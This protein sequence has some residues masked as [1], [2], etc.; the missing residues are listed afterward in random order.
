M[1]VAAPAPRERP[2]WKWVGAT[3]LLLSMQTVYGWLPPSIL[4]HMAA[5]LGVGVRAVQDHFRDA[6]RGI[7]QSRPAWLLPMHLVAVQEC[8]DFL[9]AWRVLLALDV[10]APYASVERALWEAPE[11]LLGGLQ[12]RE[13][14]RRDPSQPCPLCD[15]RSH[16]PDA[17]RA[18]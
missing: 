7:A 1:V 9:S 16:R 12:A 5:T 15:G 18:A 3:H 14:A 10:H 8:P 17:R 11:L 13:L 2:N 6:V 4:D